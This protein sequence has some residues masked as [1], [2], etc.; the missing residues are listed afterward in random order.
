MDAVAVGGGRCDPQGLLDAGRAHHALDEMDGPLKSAE[1]V[2]LEA[3]GQ[4]QQEH[5]LAVGGA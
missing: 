1:R 4:Q 5:R 2:V 3:V